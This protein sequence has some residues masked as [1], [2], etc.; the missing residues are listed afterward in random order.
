MCRG[1]LHPYL[2]A[3]GGGSE[4][5]PGIL[6]SLFA[7]KGAPRLTKADAVLS[8]QER[9]SRVQMA[10]GRSPGATQKSPCSSTGPP[11]Y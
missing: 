3:P 7:R 6:I 10:W 4:L 2:P 9:R 1:V 8:P 11:A 5:G